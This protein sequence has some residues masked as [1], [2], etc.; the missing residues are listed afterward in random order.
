M[1][2]KPVDFLSANAQRL[3]VAVST[4]LAVDRVPTELEIFGLASALRKIE[5]YAVSDQEFDIVIKK[6]HVAL[7]VDMGVGS[8]VVN[9]HD[10][11]LQARKAQINPFYWG[12]YKTDLIKQGWGA[13]VVNSLD[14][15]TD[16][17]LDLMGNPV[18]K[19]G[20][21]RRG[22]VMGDVQSGKT[23]NYTGLICKAA[24]AGYKLVILLTGTLESLRRQTQERLDSGFVGL[25]SSGVVYSN[26]RNRKRK[27][28]GVGLINATRSAGVF[29]STVADFRAT[30]VNQLGFRLRD[31]NEPV[32]L[33]VKKN[34]KIIENLTEWLKDFNAESSGKI[35]LPLLLVDDEADNASINTSPKKAT[36]INSGIRT[37]LNIF[38]KSSYV[39]FTATPFAN[40]FINPETTNEMEGDDLFP[41][42]FIYALDAPTNYLGASAIFG[43]ESRVDCLQEISD[44]EAAFPKGQK[45]DSPVD[46]VPDSLME[47]VKC[48]L[49]ANAIMDLRTGM[50]KHRSMLI[51]VSHFTLIQ[52]Q[53]KDIV[54]F[55]LR[56]VQDDIRS[57][58]SLKVSEAIK[59]NTINELRDIF[60]KHYSNHGCT[61]E[62]VQ[63][64][65]ATAVLPI[66]VRS[67]NQK[68]GGAS[69]NYALYK[70]NG[71]RVIAVG[72]NSLARGLTLEGLCVSYFYRTTQ[73]YDALLQ[74]GRWFGYR[75]GYED[76]L[77]IWM[78]EETINWYSL[79]SE[80][81]DELRGEVRRMQLS[82]LKPI[83]FGLR[84]RSHPDSLI[85]TAR[86]KMRDSESIVH[87]LSISKES[88][89]SA[90]LLSDSNAISSNHKATQALVKKIEASNFQ[91]DSKYDFPVWIGVSKAVVVEFLNNF[92]SHPL[93][94]KLQSK[95]LADFIGG[96]ND[97]KL[98]SWYVA[99]PRGSVSAYELSPG[100]MVSRRSRK[101]EVDL[102]KQ[103]LL[104]NEK[105]MRVGS[106]ADEKIGLKESDIVEAEQI[107]RENPKN[108]D[109]K[110]V[111]GKAYNEVR[112]FPLLL[113]HLV[114]PE[115]GDQKYTPLSADS[116]LVA[117]GLSFPELIAGSQK[118]TYQI[119]MVELRSLLA[120]EVSSFE[121]DEDED[122]NVDD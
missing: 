72:G 55:A 77:K 79:I 54:D 110:N 71:L 83:D 86:N 82:R 106:A 95:D 27:E 101:I 94:L 31:Y 4:S 111:P 21:P 24:D 98:D 60:V 13:K 18:G 45:S 17:I 32:L 112:K 19:S 20:W 116:S 41:R 65:L 15:V 69:L 2:S 5:M 34:K 14:K 81:T 76:L 118:M 120:K 122:E 47:A 12:R 80:A 103:S 90:R 52:D 10:P 93:N 44:A 26:S 30:T 23:S 84:V 56:G 107:F 102:D 50:P 53:V 113:I 33:V 46:C 63:R 78:P 89:E 119:N 62:Q 36:A 87:T 64:T 61:W 85:I 16:E 29:T 88:L 66:E 57:Y 25:D 105:K 109:K 37:L 22:L 11:W 51:N 48:F 74:M 75:V 59:N 43:D 39:G 42:D 3:E 108:K 97:S 9:E 6:L 115:F 68:S 121:G 100:R 49:V 28:I 91:V 96:S 35:D 40:V 1:N 8:Y 38:P 114:W 99:I 7:A 73:M 58:S 67:V 92:I 117:I 70:E 104:V